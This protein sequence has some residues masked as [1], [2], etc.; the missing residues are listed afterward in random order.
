MATYIPGWDTL[1]YTFDIFGTYTDSSK[2]L[3]LF[4][5]T[6][7]DESYMD[8]LVP[9]NASLNT[10]I[11]RHSADLRAFTSRQKVEERFSQKAG[12]SGGYGFFSAEFEATFKTSEQSDVSYDYALYESYS[13]QYSLSLKN[14]TESGLAIWVK[15]DEDYQNIPDV[16]NEENRA[17]FFRF[18]QKYGLYFVK[19]VEVG[20]RLYYCASVN[21][22]EKSTTKD[23]EVKFAMEV[24]AVFSAK[25]SSA[26][27]WNKIGQEWASN[28][29]VKV[30]A[31]GGSSS[32]LN[33]RVPDFGSNDEE[34]LGKWLESAEK[35]PAIVDFVLKPI[36]DIFSGKRATA[37][38]A[39]IKDYQKHLMFI[40]SKTGSC[41]IVVDNKEALPQPQGS[42]FLGFQLVAVN[43]SSIRPEFKRSYTTYEW[44]SGL[45][46]TYNKMLVDIE[47]YNNDKYIILF[48]TFSCFARSAPNPAFAKFLQNCGADFGLKDWLD[49]KDSNTPAPPSTMGLSCDL[50]HNN[51]VM[52]GIPGSA[53]GAAHET[54]TRT[55]SCDT[56]IMHWTP[57]NGN[58][59][60]PPAPVA[61]MTVDLFLLKNNKIDPKKLTAHIP[62]PKGYVVPDTKKKLSKKK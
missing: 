17:L 55:G 14:A 2:R 22:S 6:F 24:N 26:T 40:E 29:I 15:N 51:Y 7:G 28:R 8:Y 39:A 44:W 35:S 45:E 13:R 31:T 32:I 60:N 23:I 36:S 41:L 53:P 54:Y 46:E 56:G 50:V 49:T 21:K 58:W 30:I 34:A 10:A 57:S 59:L 1:G 25:A 62:Y 5:V 52:V 3:P 27:E 38:L 4:D 48:T 61:A 18:F 16:F 9:E 42:K 37:V 33:M 19:A 20:S 11:K 43:R 47:K 12:I